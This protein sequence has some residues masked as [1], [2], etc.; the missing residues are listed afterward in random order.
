MRLLKR[1][2]LTAYGLHNDEDLHVRPNIRRFQIPVFS[3]DEEAMLLVTPYISEVPLAALRG[4][5]FSSENPLLGRLA[6]PLDGKDRAR[7]DG[8]KWFEHEGGYEKQRRALNLLVDDFASLGSV[9]KLKRGYL[10]HFDTIRR[11]TLVNLA[12]TPRLTLILDIEENDW[13]HTSMPFLSATEKNKIGRPQGISWVQELSLRGAE[14]F[15][16]RN[17]G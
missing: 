14:G 8:S 3:E 9:Y 5:N 13:L 12:Q 7:A 15:R 11:H 10:N 2:A 4:T 1:E 17:G 16:E 6:W